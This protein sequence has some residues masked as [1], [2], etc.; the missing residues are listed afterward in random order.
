MLRR[1]FGV[2]MAKFNEILRREFKRNP[3][4]A[5]LWVMKTPDPIL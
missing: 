2:N 3:A 4:K 1:G 5:Y